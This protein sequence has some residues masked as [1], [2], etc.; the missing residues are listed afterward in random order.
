M[1]GKGNDCLFPLYLPIPDYQGKL[2]VRCGHCINC[3]AHRAQEWCMRLE[4]ES[5]YWKDMCFVTLTY[6]DDNLPRHIIDG[7]LFYSDEEIRCHPELAYVF[8][9]TLRP[10][11]LRNFI[12]RV[13]KRVPVKLRYYAVGEYGTK[14]GRS[15]LHILFF[16]LPYNKLTEYIV[17]DCWPFGFVQ[18][19]PFFKETC[20]Y[21]AGYVQ[22]KLYGREK[23]WFKLPEFMRCSHHLGEQWLLDNLSYFD[24]QHPWI[25]LNGYIYGLPR[26]FRKIL[27]EKGRLT[28]TSLAVCAELQKSEYKDLCKNLD[29]KKVSLSDFFSYRIKAAVEKQK[30]RLSSRVKTG[31]I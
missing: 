6:D 14:Y 3:K 26:Q 21:I 4:M 27:I 30:R 23:Y 19:R 29:L 12:K 17:K 24:D 18:I 8:E 7:S 22:K 5:K 1:I 11:H 13:R 15:H 28:K 31:D 9:P 25:N 16:G 10:D 2:R 20:T